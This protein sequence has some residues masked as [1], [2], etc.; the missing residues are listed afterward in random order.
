MTFAT[1]DLC[2]AHEDRLAAGTLRVLDPVFRSFGREARFSGPAATL[3]LF[4]DNTLVR[5]ALEQ[6]GAGRVLVVDGGGSTRCALVGGNLGVLA[7]KNRWAG[8]VVYGCVRDTQELSVCNL[9]VVALAAHPRKSDKRGAGVSDV[10]VTVL[11][12]RI[13]P[14]NWIYADLDGVLVSDTPLA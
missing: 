6:D 4:E 11:G 10:P 7:E 2:D 8:I 14:G 12:T 5:A 3:K 1:T 9:G 13:A